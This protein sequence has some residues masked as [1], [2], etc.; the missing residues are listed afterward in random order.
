[1]N[2]SDVWKSAKTNPLNAAKSRILPN[3]GC[4]GSRQFENA[5][6]A[7]ASPRLYDSE[8]P[9]NRARGKAGHRFS[10]ESQLLQNAE[11]NPLSAGKTT[12]F[13]F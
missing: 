9:P 13:L 2:G 10:H 8:A 3:T 4:F 11:T 6:S 1:M 12:G 5:L 7:S